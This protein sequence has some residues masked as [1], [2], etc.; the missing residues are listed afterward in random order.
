MELPLEWSQ[1]LYLSDCLVYVSVSDTQ[2]FEQTH[3]GLSLVNANLAA[4]GTGVSP[5][6]PIPA[7]F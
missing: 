7:R 4:Q 2:D 3:G 1:F 5:V 6:K